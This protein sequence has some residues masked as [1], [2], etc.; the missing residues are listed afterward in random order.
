VHAAASSSDAR[1][2]AHAILRRSDFTI[3]FVAALAERS[4]GTT[5]RTREAIVRRPRLQTRACGRSERRDAR[6]GT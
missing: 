5:G 4:P 1:A 6:R 3:A 2:L